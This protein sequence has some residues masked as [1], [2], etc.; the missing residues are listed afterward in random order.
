MHGA[1][2]EDVIAVPSTKYSNF[3]GCCLFLSLKFTDK[4]RFPRVDLERERN[5][6]DVIDS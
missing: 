1:M 2:C 3:A 6:I 5:N 4:H